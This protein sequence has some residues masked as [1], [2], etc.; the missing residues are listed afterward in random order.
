[1]TVTFCIASHA[2]GFAE[3]PVLFITSYT[4][5]GGWMLL[6]SVLAQHT[7]EKRQTDIHPIVDVRVA[8]VEFLVAVPD[9]G[10]GEE[11]GEVREP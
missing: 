7:I 6:V 10:L 9:A 4:A 11:R 3:R 5:G 1:V 8:I 2:Q